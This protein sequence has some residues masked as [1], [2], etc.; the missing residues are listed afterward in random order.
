MME[1]EIDITTSASVV[2][3]FPTPRSGHAH[4]LFVTLVSGAH[5]G[6][7]TTLTFEIAGTAIPNSTLTIPTAAS[8][9]ART[10]VIEFPVGM[11]ATDMLE[12][13]PGDVI[14][15]GSTLEVLS[16]FEGTDGLTANILLVVRRG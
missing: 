10:H 14:A 9:I 2:C 7:D 16:G 3:I 12:P 8:A 11:S 13:D 5:A 6:T 15:T 1:R 4:R